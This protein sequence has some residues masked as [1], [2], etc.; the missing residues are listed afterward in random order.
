M[1]GIKFVFAKDEPE[2]FEKHWSGYVGEAAA[3][4]SYPYLFLKYMRLY[5][6]DLVEDLSFACIENGKCAGVAHL[7]LEKGENGELQFSYAADCVRAPLCRNSDIEKEIFAK[8]DEL[9]AEKGVS[10]CLM[11]VE[12]SAWLYSKEKKK[13]P[14]NK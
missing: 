10:K 11:M 4:W 2:P 5:A 6:K 13:I 14:P 12:P 3:P 1:G 7:F 8:I 9:A